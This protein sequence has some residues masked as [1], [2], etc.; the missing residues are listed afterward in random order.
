LPK[1]PC[2]PEAMPDFP[3]LNGARG[4]KVVRGVFLYI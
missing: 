1:L 4:L 3:F 2:A